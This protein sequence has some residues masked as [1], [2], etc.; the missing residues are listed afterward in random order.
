MNVRAVAVPVI[1]IGIA[2]VIWQFRAPPGLSSVPSATWRV[3]VGGEYRQA[4]NYD[5]LAEETP[6]RLS[7][8]C[9]EA[10]HVYV[11]GRS[12]VDGIL[13]LYPSPELKSDLSNPLPS[14][15]TTLPGK[16]ADQDVTWTTRADVIGLTTYVAVASDKPIPELEE[17]AS[18]LRRWTNSV[19]PNKSLQITNPPTGTEVRGKPGTDWP[20]GILKRADERTM[21]EALVNGPMVADEHVAGIWSSCIR[22]KEAVNPNVKKGGLKTGTLKP[23]DVTNPKPGNPKPGNSKPGNSRPGGGK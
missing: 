22:V 11:F 3:R 10:R 2:L 6:V 19:L 17:L 18:H 4:R 14:G 15:Q 1:A 13:L 12:T 20:N 16:L 5:E 21:T 9:S 7:F 23:L 8:S